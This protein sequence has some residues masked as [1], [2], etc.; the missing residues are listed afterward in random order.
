MPRAVAEAGLADARP[1]RS[2]SCP[3]RSRAEA[4]RERFAPPRRAP[5]ATS[6]STSARASAAS[7]RSTCS[8]TSAA[9]WSAA[10]ARSSATRGARRAG[11]VPARCC[12]RDR[13]E[14]DAFLD[15][16]TINVSQ[17]WRH[18]EQ[19]DVA[20]PRRAARA[21]AQRGRIR[22]WS[23]GC[24]YGA[25]AY[26][27][28]A[29]AHERGAA[30][31]HV[32]IT[33]TDIDRAH[34]RARPR[35]ASSPPGDARTRRRRRSWARWF[36]KRPTA[37]FEA[38]P[39]LR[40][41][42]AA[43]RS[44]TCCASA[45]GRGAYDLVMCRNTV[46]YFNDE[47]RDALHARLVTRAAARRLPRRRRHR[48]RVRPGRHRPRLHPP[49]HLPED[50]MDIAQYLPM[51]MA[52][53]RE[54]LQELNLAVVRVEETPDDRETVDEIFRIAH[55]LKGMSATMGFEGMASLTHH[56]EDVFEL[57]KQRRGG[58]DRA[59]IDVLLECLDA[60]EAAVDIDRGRRH[61]A[62]RPGRADRAPAGARARA[63][64]PRPRPPAAPDPAAMA[65]AAVA[66]GAPRRRTSSCTLDRRRAHAVRAR[67]HG[68]G[69]R[70]PSTASSSPPPRT[71]DDVEGFD[72]REVEAWLAT[73]ARGRGRDR[74][75]RA[76][77]PTSPA[78]SAT[79]LAAPPTSRRGRAAAEAAARRRR[80]RRAAEPPRPPSADRPAAPKKAAATVRVDAER[81]DAAHAPHGRARRAPHA[82]RV[83]RRRGRRARA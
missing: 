78:P 21:R 13:D 26:T 41:H 67:L 48:A 55:S 80:A 22:A 1:R 37:R 35:P 81:L 8:S 72:G 6:T 10:S 58:L 77:S 5:R 3:P 56:M 28:A 79:E 15:R 2:T 18:P 47:V 65:A 75:R 34:G 30:G 63:R 19:F 83:A 44:A 36:T 82:R 76:A 49:L 23:A 7:A 59:A 27:L 24:S 50:L 45:R 62:P 74:D 29:V 40:A 31:A 43:S 73:D 12:A 20:R 57:L 60:L 51:F 69:R 53:A 66:A 17:L 71:S 11:R 25:E 68:A 64:A 33:G 70:S 16:V 32:A 4:G 61:R 38:L 14:L 52:E 54:H 42:R 9:R 46:I 39:E